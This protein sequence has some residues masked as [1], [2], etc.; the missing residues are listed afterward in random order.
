M[1]TPPSSPWI[2]LRADEPA[3]LT[4][5]ET[6]LLTGLGVSAI[7]SR[8]SRGAFPHAYTHPATRVRLIP[9]ADVRAAGLLH[10]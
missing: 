7:R 10:T 4:V 8:L 3:E 9:A 1:A 5:N 6:S 2:T